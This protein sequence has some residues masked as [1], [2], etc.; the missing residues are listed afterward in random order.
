MMEKESR[1]LEGPQDP[2]KPQGKYRK[3][4]PEEA[5]YS[6]SAFQRARY[7]GGFHL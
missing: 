5:A 2:K 3:A 7:G 4:G 6:V 1:E